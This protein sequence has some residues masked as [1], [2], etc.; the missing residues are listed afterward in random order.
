M[1]TTPFRCEALTSTGKRCKCQA[2]D[3]IRH[4]DRREYLACKQHSKAP[5]F[6]PAVK[7]SECP[8]PL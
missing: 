4:A 2:V 1:R 8:P 5:V 6:R 7:V 3:C